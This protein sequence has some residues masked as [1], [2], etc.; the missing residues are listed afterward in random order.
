MN[1]GI[2]HGD[3]PAEHP[4][5]INSTVRQTQTFDDIHQAKELA[6]GLGLCIRSLVGLDRDAASDALSGFLAGIAF[7]ASQIE[8]SNLVI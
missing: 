7:N 5:A 6:K 8:L 2:G 1:L 4:C 3:C